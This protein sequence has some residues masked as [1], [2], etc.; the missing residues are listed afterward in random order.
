MNDNYRRLSNMYIFDLV[1]GQKTPVC[2]EEC[3]PKARRE[4]LMSKNNLFLT[5]LVEHLCMT[6]NHIGDALDIYRDE[7]TY[8]LT[9]R[10]S[11][12][13]AEQQ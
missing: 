11:H 4:F 8:E 3:S 12:E 9:T 5:H 13:Q 1:D 7:G 2:I 6:L 10:K